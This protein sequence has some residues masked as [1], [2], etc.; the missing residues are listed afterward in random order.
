MR[1]VLLALVLCP[2]V[3]AAS[4]VS[5]ATDFAVEEHWGTTYPSGPPTSA[6]LTSYWQPL[7]RSTYLGA[8]VE[9]RSFVEY[10][11]ASLRA[12][13]NGQWSLTLAYTQDQYNPHYWVDQVEVYR[14][15]GDGRQSIGKFDSGDL[16]ASVSLQ[17]RVPGSFT[18]DVTDAVSDA[19]AGN[20]PYL[21]FGFRLPYGA[22][23][24]LLCYQRPDL[25][26]APVPEPSCLLLLASS[27]FLLSGF[28]R[29]S[30]GGK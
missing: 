27:A 15:E 22:G 19:F 20:W 29:L 1:A 23:Q 25:S 26:F 8:L 21:G 16:L 5:P 12:K 18:V 28:R 9:V 14:Y 11:S 3:C 6:T 2:T 7:E 10:D 4:V 24:E 13:G 17:T 30:V